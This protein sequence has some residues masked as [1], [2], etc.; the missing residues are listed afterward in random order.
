MSVNVGWLPQAGILIAKC[1]VH[2]MSHGGCMK[3]D[4]ILHLLD[5]SALD[6]MPDSIKTGVVR[7]VQKDFEKHQN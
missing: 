4:V 1:I 5:F 6:Q 2:I 7:N 3:Y